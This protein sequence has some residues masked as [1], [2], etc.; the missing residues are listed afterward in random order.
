[1]ILGI[2]A[3]KVEGGEL[4][5]DNT[6]TKEHTADGIETTWP[7]DY[8]F[9][10]TPVVKLNSVVQTVG[11][12]NIDK[13]VDFDCLWDFNQK[14]VKFST[15]PSVGDTI[16]ITAL[17]KVPILVQVENSASISQ[18]GRFEFS[19]VDTTIQSTEET[20]QYAEAQLTS[21]AGTVRE[22][23]FLTYNTGLV[24]GQTIQ[25]NSVKR[26]V[27][28]IFVIQEVTLSMRT[29]TEGEWTVALATI[30]TLGMIELLQQLLL[31]DKQ[32]LDINENVVIKKYYLDE[33]AVAI[34]ELITVKMKMEDFQEIEIDEDIAK[35]PFGPNTPP[36]FVLAPYTP[37]GQTDP[38][39]EFRLD[40]S[41]LS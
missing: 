22:G 18:Y 19:K 9:A 31:R 3:V 11:L 32:N 14:Y 2:N 33:Q 4:T 38:K 12:D 21:Y 6:R 7:T 20:K 8:K 26:D 24:S 15:L 39:R 16:E 29:P 25:I 37:T 17:Y 23:G 13:A 27:V 36:E 34:Q 28:D 30:K 1:M 35:D 41:Y 40:R 5:S 10:E